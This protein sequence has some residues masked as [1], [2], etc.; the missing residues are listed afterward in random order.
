ML[1]WERWP[2]LLCGVGAGLS[3]KGRAEFTGMCAEQM[4]ETWE[5]MATD[6]REAPEKEGALLWAL[7][8]S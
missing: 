7:T 3:G 5:Q 6:G 8:Q 4:A 1:S 2:C